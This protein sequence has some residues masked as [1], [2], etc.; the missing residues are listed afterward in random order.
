MMR[1]TAAAGLLIATLAAGVPC[2]MAEPTAGAEPGT[3]A[4]RVGEQ[5]ITVGQVR[6]FLHGVTG[7]HAV[8]PQ[9]LAFVEAQALEQ[10]VDRQLV[11]LFLDR[12]GVK[13]GDGELDAAVKSLE[14]QAG[15][16]PGG[17]AALAA[18]RGISVDSLREQLAWELRW[19]KYLI[20]EM[21]DDKLKAFFQAHRPEF[22]G[23][24]VRVSHILLRPESA[25]DAAAFAAL[26]RQATAIRQQIVGGT[27]TFAEAAEKYSAGPSRRQGGDLGFIPR[28]N[29]MVEAFSAAAFAL[30]QGEI[31]PPVTTSFG[32]HLILCTEIRPGKQDWEQSREALVAA[33]A[34][35]LFRQL[36]ARM[37]GGVNVTY[38]GTLPHLDPATHELIDRASP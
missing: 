11:T 36:A 5:P 32:I 14:Q 15:Q 16:Q 37:R 38:T 13:L 6:Q 8:N 20:G 22:D 31:S 33:L 9:V 30:H 12:Q 18:K 17:L 28:H 19:K 1:L 24:Q 26:Q 7:E 25:R 2:A 21:T 29:R 35:D 3:V 10:L 4:A 27:T 23:T 34:Q